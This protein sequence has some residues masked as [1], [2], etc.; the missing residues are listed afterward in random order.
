MRAFSAPKFLG[1]IAVNAVLVWLAFAMLSSF[2]PEKPKANRITKAL[3]FITPAI[4]V[5]SFVKA[6]CAPLADATFHN[7]WET[8]KDVSMLS[9]IRFARSTVQPGDR[10]LVF[11]YPDFVYYGRL[12]LTRELDPI[13]T[14]YYQAP[15][16]RTAFEALRR[17]G[18]THI[19]IPSYEVLSLTLS[20][21]YDII[22]NPNL[23]T[24][25]NENRTGLRL[26]KLADTYSDVPA[27]AAVMMSFD[28]ASGT[29]SPYT[30]WSTFVDGRVAHVE[31]PA[32]PHLSN[33]TRGDVSLC[34]GTSNCSGSYRT[35]GAFTDRPLLQE[36]K[37]YR[38]SSTLDGFGKV[39][40]TL[41][42]TQPSPQRMPKMPVLVWTTIA[43][44][45]PKKI[46]QV[47]RMPQES[48]GFVINFMLSG[49]GHFTVR[50]VSLDALEPGENPLK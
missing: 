15:D 33:D 26:F 40:A 11:K 42:V 43:S 16:V 3:R 12:N 8:A 28:G 21:T 1:G 13:L 19:Y 6:C 29:M 27:N 35:P 37:L 31:M 10:Y 7:D 49:G 24:L 36:G 44:E 14:D 46:S 18:I 4:G 17:I 47:F 32:G 38:I 30:G 39:K 48:R 25:I 41:L 23:A 5:E 50:D 2:P 34:F 9:V 20:R 22:S 45:Q